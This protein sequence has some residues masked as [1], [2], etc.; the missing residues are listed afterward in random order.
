M[1]NNDVDRI[2]LKQRCIEILNNHHGPHECITMERLYRTITGDIVIPY[3]RNN[4]SRIV[5]D[6]VAQLQEEGHPICHKSGKYGGYFLGT[7]KEHIE[8]EATWFRARAMTSLQRSQVLM[9]QTNDELLAQLKID[10]E[11]KENTHD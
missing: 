10:L 9:K 6:L 1:S 3:K 5:R 2:T 8:K 7:K 11:P 4:Q